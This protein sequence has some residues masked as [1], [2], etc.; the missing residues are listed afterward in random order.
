MTIQFQK[1]PKVND[2]ESDPTLYGDIIRHCKNY[3]NFMDSSKYTSA[4]ECS[5]GVANDLRLMSG[6]WEGKNGFYLGKD[7]AIILDEPKFK[8]SSITQYIP[9]ELHSARYNL[10]VTGQTEWEDK[11][12]YIYDEGVAYINGAWAAIELKE[13][14]NYVE[15]Y[16]GHR[17]YTIRP[18]APRKSMLHLMP[19]QFKDTAGN[20]I[21]DGHIEFIPYMAAVLMKTAEGTL[22]KQ[23]ID[24]SRW[25]FR[26]A[27]N[28]YYRQLKDGLSSYNVQDNLWK[29]MKT[30]ACYEKQRAFLKSVVE[31]EFPEGEVPEDDVD[32][33]PWYI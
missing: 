15:A 3:K 22:D 25:L 1:Y 7:R 30:A 32:P 4:H 14:E 9:T 2:A 21:V 12:L 11:P 16:Q 28:A 19:L 8:K 23:L 17:G 29:T 26:H 27:T 20:T 33:V 13:K 5:H 18:Y 24:F 10:Y 31:F 6:N